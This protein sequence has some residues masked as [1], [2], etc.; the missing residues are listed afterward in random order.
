MDSNNEIKEYRLLKESI[1]EKLKE[2]NNIVSKIYFDNTDDIIKCIKLV[3]DCLKNRG[4]L[5]FIGN[6]GSAS[7]SDHI[8][9]EFVGIKLP[10]ISLSSNVAN[11]TATAN[12]YGYENVF[13]KQL[14]TL[15]NDKDI[16]IALS[17]SGNSSNILK[18]IETANSKNMNVI[19]ITG[20]SGGRLKCDL[21]KDDICIQIPS[22]NTQRI[23]E[24]TLVILHIIFESIRDDKK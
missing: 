23:Q 22:D 14:E 4:K 24:A 16:L 20:R 7:D 12:D 18:C 5:I 8:V 17:T 13:S 19:G 15:A 11:I 1:I 6:G 3:K 2:H 9:A 21:S 10:A